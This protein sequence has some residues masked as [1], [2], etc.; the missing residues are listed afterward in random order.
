MRSLYIY[1]P[2]Q[3]G[4]SFKSDYLKKALTFQEI[5]LILKENIIFTIFTIVIFF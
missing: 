3:E 4:Y 5:F 2:I 1:I